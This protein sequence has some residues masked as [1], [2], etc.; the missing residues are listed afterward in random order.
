MQVEAAYDALFMTAMNKRMKGELE[1]S[2][3]VR[4]AD[5]QK[6]R[7][8]APAVSCQSLVG[9]SPEPLLPDR[10]NCRHRIQD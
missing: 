1:V 7:K 6:V 8:A 2:Q 3:S 9:L 5:V 10:T 4:F